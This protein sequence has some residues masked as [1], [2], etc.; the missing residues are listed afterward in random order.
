MQE[1]VWEMPNCWTDCWN[2]VPAVRE[3]GQ[4]IALHLLG[5]SHYSLLILGEEERNPAQTPSQ[6]LH[7]NTGYQESKEIVSGFLYIWYC[8]NSKCFEIFSFSF[9]ISRCL[10]KIKIIPN[11]FLLYDKFRSQSLLIYEF[12]TIALGGRC[13]YPI[14]RGTNES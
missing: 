14:Y 10:W 8:H 1:R 5:I 6:A 9:I 13:Y 3:S 2:I 11:W 7:S 12:F 4:K